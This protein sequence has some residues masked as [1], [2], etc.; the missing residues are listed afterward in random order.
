MKTKNSGETS[1]K[2]PIKR[3][4]T[5]ERRAAI[6]KRIESNGLWN[7]SKIRLAEEFKVNRDTILD[8]FKVLMANIDELDLKETEVHIGASYREVF[9]DMKAMAANWE[10]EPNERTNAARAMATIGQSLTDH[11]EA[12]GRKAPIKQQIELSGE[13]KTQLFAIDNSAYKKRGAKA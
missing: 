10:L 1:T 12:Y 5:E 7:I 3:H 4:N 8:D 2:K 13:V 9:E 6:K 11:L